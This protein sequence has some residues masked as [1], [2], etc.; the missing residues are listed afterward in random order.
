MERQLA[1]WRALVT[2]ASAG[3]G[4]A[5]ARRLAAEG[6]NLVLTARR[7]ERL[8]RLAVALRQAY[9]VDVRVEAID[10]SEPR[11]GTHLYERTE[12]QGLAIDLLVNNAGFGTYD[13][14]LNTS[15]GRLHDE[16]SVNVVALTE[17]TRAFVPHM[18]ERG[19]GHVMNIASI[20]AWLP[21]PDF[22]VYA[23]T[24]AY[25]RN[26]T[27]A[28]DYEL[29]GTGVRAICVAPGGTKTEFTEV[30][31]QRVKSSGERMMMTAERCADIAVRKMLAGRRTVITGWLNSLM[32][33][34]LRFLPRAL[35]PWVGHRSM[36]SSVDKVKV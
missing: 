31:G 26:F 35:M 23:A 29:K 28:L 30:A 24:K 27:E 34:S 7:K 36:S 3:I 1:G 14:F 5:L 22:A 2:G 16:L 6:A 25:V 33:W 11:A 20:A 12:G 9:G 10:L 19:R 13:L 32:M 17:L 8:E 15:W 21:C 18:V 4:E